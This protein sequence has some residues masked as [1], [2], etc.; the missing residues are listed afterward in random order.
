MQR[1]LRLLLR[2]T[3]LWKGTFPKN[4]LLVSMGNE[5]PE[6]RE[7][8]KSIPNEYGISRLAPRK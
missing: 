8:N 7:S 2:V 6:D 5:W 1:V 4:V 3:K